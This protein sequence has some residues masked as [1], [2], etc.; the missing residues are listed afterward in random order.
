METR[1]EVNER[2]LENNNTME[3]NKVMLQINNQI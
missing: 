3:I 2:I 1:S